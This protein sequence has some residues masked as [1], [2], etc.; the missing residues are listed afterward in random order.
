MFYVNIGGSARGHLVSLL[1]LAWPSAGWDVG[2][3]MNESSA[4]QAVV[5]F[6]GPADLTGSSF[7]SL[8]AKDLAGTVF[9]ASSR[10]DPVLAEASPL[11]YIHK[12]DPPFLIVQGNEDMTVP[13]VQFQ[14]LYR[15]LTSAG[16]LATLI[17]VQNA[18]HGFIPVGGPINPTLAQID[19]MAVNF[20]L[21][22]LKRF[23]DKTLWLNS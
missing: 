15:K 14:I 20:F 5:D 4:L 23:R 7:D 22:I 8:L 1:G 9:G 18:G 2:E 12:G 17:M 13:P 19:T 21:I 10:K 3:Y 16:N 6:F 11:T